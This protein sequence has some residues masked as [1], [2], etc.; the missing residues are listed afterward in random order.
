MRSSAADFGQFREVRYLDPDKL[1]LSIDF[2]ITKKKVVITTLTNENV[3]GI[4]LTDPVVTK[5]FGFIFDFLW[6]IA[7]IK[8]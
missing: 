6:G 2:R 3:V 8:E 1:P 5:N 7:E 4:I